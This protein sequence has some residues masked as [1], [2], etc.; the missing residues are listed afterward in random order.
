MASPILRDVAACPPYPPLLPGKLWL[1]VL[2][3]LQGPALAAE[4]RARVAAVRDSEAPGTGA[5]PAVD[6]HN[7]RRATYEA[8]RVPPVGALLEKS[9]HRHHREV[10]RLAEKAGG[11]RGVLRVAPASW[12]DLLGVGV[13]LVRAR[14]LGRAGREHLRELPGHDSRDLRAPV[15]VENGEHG[16]V[17]QRRGQRRHCTGRVLHRWAPSLH[18][19]RCPL[20]RGALPTFRLLLAPRCAH[21]TCNTSSSELLRELH[22]NDADSH[23]DDPFPCQIMQKIA[24]RYLLEKED[25]QQDNIEV[26]DNPKQ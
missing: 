7:D 12:R 26:P 6:D 2:R 18:L 19:R 23:G 9:V 14:Q 16:L 8:E 10:Q 20:Q 25:D 3:Q 22:N 11:L 21:R 1:V 15:P 4:D 13:R 24:S 17:R 5:V